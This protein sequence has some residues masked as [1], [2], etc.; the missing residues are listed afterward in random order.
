MSEFPRSSGFSGLSPWLQQSRS[1]RMSLSLG[2]S[3]ESASRGCTC[4]GSD[5]TG[6]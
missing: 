2:T 3:R 5:D 1:V 6:F 4:P